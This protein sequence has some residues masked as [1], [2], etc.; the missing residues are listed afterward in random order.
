MEPSIAPVLLWLDRLGQ[1]R[2]CYW[3]PVPAHEAGEGCPCYTAAPSRGETGEQPQNPAP[4]REIRVPGSEPQRV[5]GTGQRRSRA[6]SQSLE[7][8]IVGDSLQDSLCDRCSPP[9]GHSH[10]LHVSLIPSLLYPPFT[11]RNYPSGLHI[12]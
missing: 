3:K 9:R 10:F 4:G 7:F 2:T 12:S 8:R 6:P 5:K 11:I 1:V